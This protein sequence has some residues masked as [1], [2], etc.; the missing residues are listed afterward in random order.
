MCGRG[1][2][3]IIGASI[4]AHL[5]QQDVRE[6]VVGFRMGNS[7]WFSF[8]YHRKIQV[9]NQNLFAVHQVINEDKRVVGHDSGDELAQRL[10]G[11]D[12]V[13]GFFRVPPGTSGYDVPMFQG[14]KG[15]EVDGLKALDGDGTVGTMDT[16]KQVLSSRELTIQRRLIAEQKKLADSFLAAERERDATIGKDG[17]DYEEVRAAKLQADLEKH[18]QTEMGKIEEKIREETQSQWEIEAREFLQPLARAAHFPN[19]SLFSDLTEIG[20]RDALCEGVQNELNNRGVPVVAQSKVSEDPVFTAILAVTHF[21]ISKSRRWSDSEDVRLKSP[22]EAFGPVLGSPELMS[23]RESVLVGFLIRRFA[24]ISDDIHSYATRWIIDQTYQRVDNFA[25]VL[26]DIKRKIPK[27]REAV[28]RK[29]EVEQVNEVQ[30]VFGDFQ[31]VLI[32]GEEGDEEEGDRD[33][34]AP[35]GIF[36]KNVLLADEL[37]I[38]FY[39]QGV[40]S[41][42]CNWEIPRPDRRTLDCLL[43][44]GRGISQLQHC[45]RLSRHGTWCSE[46]GKHSRPPAAAGHGCCL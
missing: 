22:E 3:Y 8:L 31:N 35:P 12:I 33:H 5:V 29:A 45:L 2:L 21:F 24:A 1:E 32:D 13:G 16:R 44:S 42:C 10:S 27:N 39:G 4:I 9:T 25:N 34:Q 38:A 15:L 17:E 41:Q 7:S 20:E 14:I 37:S 23:L 11:L 26:N 30:G 6:V 28:R 36:S 40:E 46:C 18:R 43:R 19:P